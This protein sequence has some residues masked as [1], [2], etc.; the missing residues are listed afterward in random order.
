MPPLPDNIS[1]DLRDFLQLCFIKDPSARPSAVALSLHPW[2]CKDEPKIVS[3]PLEPW[4]ALTSFQD[5]H[6]DSIPFLRRVSIN[7]QRPSSSVF[8]TYGEDPPR[9]PSMALTAS[10]PSSMAMSEMSVDDVSGYDQHQIHAAETPARTEYGP[11][12]LPPTPRKAHKLVKTSFSKG[13]RFPKLEN[14]R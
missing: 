11:I 8:P 1:D 3:A 10:R 4:N 2:V 12:S 6:M 5:R 7:S 14:S 13:E 9:P